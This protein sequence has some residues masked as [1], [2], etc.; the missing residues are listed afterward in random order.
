VSHKKINLSRVFTVFQLLITLSLL[1]AVVVIYLQVN[2]CINSD[3]GINKSNLAVISIDPNEFAS[4]TDLK[5]QV[6]ALPE[7]ISASGSSIMPPDVAIPTITTKSAGSGKTITLESINVDVGFFR[8]MGISFLSGTDFD[9]SDSMKS[10]YAYIL[11]KEAVKVLGVKGSGSH[12]T[13]G[14]LPVIGIVNDFNVHTMYDRINPTVFTYR[15]MA[16]R[17]V[18][19]RY[20]EGSWQ[21]F[22]SGVEKIWKRLAPGQEFDMRQF[23]GELT[24]LYKKERTFGY[25]V[26]AFTILALIIM[27]MGLF[28]LALLIS[29]RKTKETAIR[30]VFGA[31]NTDILFGMQKEFLIYIAIA[32][33]FAIPLTT[34]FLRIWLNTFYYRISLSWWIFVISVTGVTIFVSTIILTRTLRVLRENPVKALKYE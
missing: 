22:S 23:S 2:F 6:S 16:I 33:A 9:P 11:N 8:T 32:S 19:I 24:N 18:I 28:G 25:M 7:V 17:A 26:G 13:F 29:E 1:I 4:Y 14:G 10:K 34:F 27:G 15:R 20:R 5:D 31:T 3:I 21:S 12:A 30:K